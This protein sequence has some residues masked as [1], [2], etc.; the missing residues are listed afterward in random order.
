[1]K[2]ANCTFIIFIFFLGGPFSSLFVSILFQLSVNFTLLAGKR[3]LCPA[4]TY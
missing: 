2:A 4:L 3:S 1:M